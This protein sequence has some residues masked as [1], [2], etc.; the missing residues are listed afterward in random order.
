MNK[1]ILLITFCLLSFCSK[2]QY[3]VLFCTNADSLG[4]CKEGG[5]EFVWNGEKFP[6]HLIVMN[7][8][9][10][11]TPKLKYMMFLMKNDRE[12]V[13]NADLSLSVSPLGMF[14]V[15][16]IFFFKPG[17]Y[18][19]DVLDEHDKYLATGFVTITDRKD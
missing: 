6:L 10:L 19:I 9:G 1:T 2:A 8:N 13:L 14:A 11:G 5:N 3:E 7:K 17:Y 12:G 18:K 16:K 15:K 4:N